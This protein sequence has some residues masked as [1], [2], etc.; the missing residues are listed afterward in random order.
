MRG[1][2]KKE[3]RK[4]SMQDRRVRVRQE[5]GKEW[6]GEKMERKKEGRV[7]ESEEG[8]GREVKEEDA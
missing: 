4:G 6:E 3:A 8:V 5:G 1:G 7:W 2:G